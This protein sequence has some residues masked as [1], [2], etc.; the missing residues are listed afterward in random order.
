MPPT[1]PWPLAST[2]GGECQ[3]SEDFSVSVVTTFGSCTVLLCHRRG[4]KGQKSP[5]PS[6]EGWTSKMEEASL[7]GVSSLHL[8]SVLGTSVPQSPSS[9]VTGPTG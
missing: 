8:P 5:S 6:S 3:S 2:P 9:R 1:F 7:P 4:L